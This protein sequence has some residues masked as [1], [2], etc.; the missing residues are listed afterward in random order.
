LATLLGKKKTLSARMA[1]DQD[2][3]KV[4]PKNAMDIKY[5]DL[6]EDQRQDFKIQL[7]EM[8]DDPIKFSPS[9]RVNV[10]RDNLAK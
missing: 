2:K 1:E 9:I 7:K 10:F 3:S 6:S 4:D 8:Y 5:Y